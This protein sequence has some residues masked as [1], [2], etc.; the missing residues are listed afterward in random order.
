MKVRYLAFVI[1][2]TMIVSCKK[3]HFMNNGVIVG[4]N[5]GFC[6]TCGGFY[7]NLSNDTAINSN[8]YYVINYSD[9][10]TGLINQYSNEYNKNHTPIFVS[11]NY[12]PVSGAQANWIRVTD[13]SSR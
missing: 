11:V 12:V 7:L 10:L 8:T 9:N 3:D 5:Y 1:V 4:W 2:L 6:A 13:I